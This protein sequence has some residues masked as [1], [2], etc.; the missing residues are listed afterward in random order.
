MELPQIIGITGRKHN[1]KDTVGNYL[2]DHYGYKRIAFADKIKEACILIFGLS[3]EQVFDENLK[4]VVDDFWG[5]SP[6][7]LLQYVGTDLLRNQLKQIMPHI[8]NNIWVKAVHKQIMD[9]WK[10]NPGQKF[11]VTDIRFE[12]ELQ[13]IKELGGVTV[14][15]TRP[16]IENTDTHSSETQISQFDVEYDLL[17]DT[18]IENLYDLVD[19]KVV[20]LKYHSLCHNI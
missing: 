2:V 19:C 3:R 1:G 13:I 14:R 10:S 8:D 12:N 15:V 9:E 17:N 5:V 16:T 20:K 7:T 4:E 18:T 11:V 6:R